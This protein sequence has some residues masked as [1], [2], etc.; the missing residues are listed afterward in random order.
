MA[1][2]KITFGLKNVH[3]APFTVVGGVINYDT[4]IAIP[5]AVELSLEARG[6][7]VEFYADN[8][9]Y[10]SAQNNQGYDGTLTIANIPETFLID[11]L[12]EEKDLTDLVITE[13]TTAAGKHFALMFEFVGDVKSI[14]HVLYNCTASRPTIASSTKSD[15]VEPNTNE[16]KFVA[17]ARET[18][19]AVK[20][21]TTT[22]TPDLVYNAWYSAVYE[23]NADTTAPTVTVVPADSATNVAID[24]NVVWTFNE[25]INS[26]DV[27]ATNFLLMDNAGVEVAGALS[28][29]ATNKIV[30]L[31]P[32]SNLTNNTAYTAIVIKNV[33]DLAGNKLAANTIV[34][35]TTV[36]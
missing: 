33:R 20:T 15:T 10:Y 1:E 12:G 18:D 7:L 27:V 3:Y 17:N 13:K 36:A 4:P 34:N 2:N 32:T 21:K 5:G 28:I 8:I 19:N 23:K 25:A 30:T 6:D 16:L 24:A 14:R 35:F 31:N 22:T 11:A 29:D 9:V 26:E